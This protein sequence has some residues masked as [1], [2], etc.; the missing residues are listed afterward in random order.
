MLGFCTNNNLKCLL[1]LDKIT[2]VCPTVNRFTLFRDVKVEEQANVIIV[3]PGN[4][5]RWPTKTTIGQ[6]NPFISHV[7]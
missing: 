5:D 1:Y 6:D 7:K 4:Q 2:L 3:K